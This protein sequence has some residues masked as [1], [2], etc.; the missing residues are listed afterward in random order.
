MTL[1][2]QSKSESGD[3]EVAIELAAG[4]GAVQQ[5]AMRAEGKPTGARDQIDKGDTRAAEFILLAEGIE[6]P[7]DHNQQ[8]TP[9][10]LFVDG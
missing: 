7:H 1:R 10:G 9:Y 8:L 6:L 4:S 2:W 3:A 5:G